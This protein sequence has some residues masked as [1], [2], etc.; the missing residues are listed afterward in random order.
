MKVDC[1]SLLL[2]SLSAWL[3]EDQLGNKGLGIGALLFF[4]EAIYDSL[5]GP[6]RFNRYNAA[7]TAYEAN[8]G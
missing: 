3:G 6:P 2:R 1:D 8:A 4:L 5:R 7:G